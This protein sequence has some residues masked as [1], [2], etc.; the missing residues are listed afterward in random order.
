MLLASE[1]AASLEEQ[2]EGQEEQQEEVHLDAGRGRGFG[3]NHCPL[4]KIKVYAKSVTNVL[5]L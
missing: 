4:V 5:R 2:P 1:L 3:Y